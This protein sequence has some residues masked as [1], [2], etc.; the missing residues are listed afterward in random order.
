MRT[1]H[2]FQTGTSFEG[3]PG[4]LAYGCALVWTLGDRCQD[5]HDLVKVRSSAP[6]GSPRG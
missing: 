2:P 5:L 6:R 4:S 3:A 1:H